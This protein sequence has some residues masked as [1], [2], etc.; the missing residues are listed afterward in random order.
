MP[1]GGVRPQAS[2]CPDR[3]HFALGFCSPCYYRDKYHKNP[4]RARRWAKTSTAKNHARNRDRVNA[5]KVSVGCVDCGFNE[6]SEA[7]DFDHL[8][9]EE[10]LFGIGSSLNTASWKRIEAEI[11]K[12]EVVCSNC[13]RKRTAERREAL[14]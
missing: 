11:A 12:C 14:T 1:K 8:P 2:C 9:G 4:E 13:H 3:E 7:L 10:K 5:I 6:F